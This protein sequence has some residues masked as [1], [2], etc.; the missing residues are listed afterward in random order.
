MKRI[1]AVGLLWNLFFSIVFS[2]NKE[3]ATNGDFVKTITYNLSMSLVGTQYNINKRDIEKLF[4]GDFNAPVEFFF[5]PSSEAV[6]S[7]GTPSGLRIIRD[8]LNKSSIL[9]IKYISNY[10]EANKEAEKKYPLIAGIP[11]KPDTI[12]EH[13]KAMIAKYYEEAS[14]LYKI[15]THSYPI[16]NLLA[17]KLYEKMGSF[18]GNF[19]GKGV[20]GIIFDGYSVTFRTVVEDEVWSLWILMPQGDAL[21]MTDLCLQIIK[22]A[23]ANQ[24][25]ER[26]YI[27]T[28]DTLF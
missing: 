12:A 28:L 21:K 6:P 26:E 11:V 1:I 9:E 18:I 2:Q 10:R 20:P 27:R 8:T 13:N 14:K 23:D 3:N 16:S 25:N 22:D 5:N 7:M 4:F 24:L 17:E 19:K 15:E